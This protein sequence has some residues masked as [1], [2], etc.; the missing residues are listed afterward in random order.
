MSLKNL[1]IVCSPL[2]I[3]NAIESVYHF[4]LDNNLLVIIYSSYNDNN[5]KQMDNIAKYYK[6]QEVLTIGD[7]KQRSKFFDYVKTTKK[8]QKTQYQYVFSGGFSAAMYMMVAN[9][10]KNKL[11]FLD[12]GVETITRYN[13]RLKTNKINKF[14]LKYA[15]FWLFGLK[16]KLKDR[17]NLFTY[18]N[19]K[20]L[21]N[22]EVIH[23]D[24]TFFKAKYMVNSTMDENIYFL[25]QR[26]RMNKL[27]YALYVK[28]FISN[29]NKKVIYIPHRSELVSNELKKA[30]KDQG[31]MLKYCNMPIEIYFLTNKI[32][33]YAVV[34]FFTTALLT[35]RF[36]YPNS[37]YKSIYLSE[38]S[39]FENYHKAEDIYKYIYSIG[40]ERLTYSI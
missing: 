22:I 24:L 16:T 20:L 12:D 19:L 23:N 30:L 17:I 7:G 27:K 15:R 10:E 25:G 6:W 32:T 5:N 36:L 18:F 21:P 14:R 4:D 1:F 9:V 28:E 38:S 40:V 33:P 26:L 2:Q 11:F 34:G 31:A 13:Q 29:A 3:I 35:L 8:L 39:S 37:Q